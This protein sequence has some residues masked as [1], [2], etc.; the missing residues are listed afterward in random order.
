[1][2]LQ[3]REPSQNLYF[4]QIAH[5]DSPPG[6]KGVPSQVPIIEFDLPMWVAEPLATT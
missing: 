3:S 6:R 4:L 5:K 2:P 1:M